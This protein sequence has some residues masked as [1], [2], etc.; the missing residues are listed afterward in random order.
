MKNMPY[1]SYRFVFC[2]LIG[3]LALFGSPGCGSGDRADQP[4]TAAQ[5]HGDHDH[6]HDHGH[7]APEDFVSGVAV[8]R[9]HFETIRDALGK[10]DID[11]DTAHDPLHEVG[12]LLENL[13]KLADQASLSDEDRATAQAAITAMFEA[14]GQ[15][16][17]AIHG[18]NE[19][20]YESVRDKLDKAMAD[21][22]AVVERAKP[23]T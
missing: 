5:Q 8:L 20:D 4:G 22:N 6:D 7:A 18:G 1:V 15:I 10:S 16:D 2:C 17:Q 14:Y 13:T 11:I 9:G 19:V 12:R 23:G 21:L 3:S